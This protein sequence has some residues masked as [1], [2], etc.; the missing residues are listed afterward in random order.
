[1]GQLVCA[2]VHPCCGECSVLSTGFSRLS[3][4]QR[5]SLSSPLLYSVTARSLFHSHWAVP[6]SISFDFCQ[7]VTANPQACRQRRWRLESAVGLLLWF[8]RARQ[9]SAICGGRHVAKST[10]W[11]RLHAVVD[12]SP[13]L[14]HVA[15]FC[16]A[17]SLVGPL[18]VMMAAVTNMELGSPSRG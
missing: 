7:P 14:R 12:R 8:R 15:M 3:L 1:M 4:Y 10:V 2:R 13:E 16:V 18:A 9:R 11:L 17:A 5:K 6:T